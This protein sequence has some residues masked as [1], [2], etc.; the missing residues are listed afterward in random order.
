MSQG[1][2]VPSSYSVFR[3]QGGGGSEASQSLPLSFQIILWVCVTISQC[4]CLICM[5]ELRR[6]VISKKINVSAMYGHGSRDSGCGSGHR[7][8]GGCGRW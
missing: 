8:F 2:N 4:K 6:S 5:V 3:C 1:Q 7:C